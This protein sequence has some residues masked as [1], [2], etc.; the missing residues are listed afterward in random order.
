[1]TI[2]EAKAG[3]AGRGEAEK[4]IGPMMDRQNLLSIERAHVL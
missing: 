2:E 4:R 3:I 1:L